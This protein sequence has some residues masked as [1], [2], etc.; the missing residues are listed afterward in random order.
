[1]YGL[2]Q[3]YRMVAFDGIMSFLLLMAGLIILCGLKHDSYKK[4]RTTGLLVVST[5]CYVVFY[6][7]CQHF[8]GQAVYWFYFADLII[9]SEIFAI[10][11][12]KGTVAAKSTYI[13]FYTALVVVYKQV[14]SPLYNSESLM[15]PYVY[16]FLDLASGLVMYL[17]FGI[18]TILLK[19]LRFSTSLEHMPMKYSMLFYFPISILVGLVVEVTFLPSEYYASV[20]SLVILINFPV[21]CRMFSMLISS[22]EEQRYL[23]AALTQSQA[24]L[25][26]YKND[27]VQ[28]DLIRKERHEL[29]NNYFYLQT[30]LKEKKFEEAEK[31]ISQL[32]GDFELN[33]GA[34][35]TGN[36]FLDYLINKK[37]SYARHNSINIIT[38]VYVPEDISFD[39]VS[40]CTILSNLLDNAIEYS[41]GREKSE[42]RILIHVAQNYL[43]CKI[44]NRV[45]ENVMEINP[46]LA[47]TKPDFA[48]HGY[49]LKIVEST[50]NK[51][52]G[53]FSAS[54]QQGYFVS[55]VMIPLLK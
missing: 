31:Y 54:Y 10:F 6:L 43:V 19:R 12:L 1:M 42:I 4:L 38:Q 3:F 47:T 25:N 52:N 18:F 50:V 14:C 22:Y 44:E 8:F 37:V 40:L 17:L 15:D 55:Q 32:I 20:T 41:I 46:S 27:E 7:L 11:F 16:A 21:I 13:F 2:Y 53:I 48:F 45:D 9:I 39:D 34:I 5:G 24:E 51:M 23:D 26:S 30:L 49:G 33:L 28:R 35:E 29:K 36:T